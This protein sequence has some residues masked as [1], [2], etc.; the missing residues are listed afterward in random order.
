MDTGTFSRRQWASKSLR[1]TAKE[2]SLVGSHGK[3]PAIAERFSKYQKAAEEATA[4]KKKTSV[5]SLPPLRS[6]NLSVLKKRWE[7][8]QKAVPQLNVAPVSLRSQSASSKLSGLPE[9]SMSSSRLMRQDSLNQK[10]MPCEKPAKIKM[11]METK[12]KRELE[13]QE[14]NVTELDPLSPPLEKSA[15]PLNNLKMMFEKGKSK[16]Q[17]EVGS[18]SEDMD[19][20][21]GTPSLKRS[22]S[23]RD[24][25]AKYQAAVT[26]Q[27]SFTTTR[28]A[29]QSEGSIPSTDHK[30]NTSSTVDGQKVSMLSESNCAKT[31]G[32][33]VHTSPSTA[34]SISENKDPQKAIKFHLPIQESCVSCQK[35]VYPLERLI[36]NQHIYHKTCF[37]CALC[38]TKLSLGSYASLHGIIYCKPHFSQLFKSK[39]NYDE[40]FGHRPHKELW[41]PRMNEQEPE[42]SEKPKP[43]LADLVSVKPAEQLSP[44]VEVSPQAKF[45]DMTEDLETRHQATSSTEKTQNIPVESRR[46]RVAWPPPANSEGSSKVSIPDTEGGKGL[47]KLFR[48]KWPPEDEVPP[49]QQRPERAELKSLQ[50]SSSLRERSRPFSVAQSMKLSKTSEQDAQSSLK[51]ALVRQG[52]L[53]ELR[54]LSKMKKEKAAVQNEAKL[55][56]KKAKD[57]DR[58]SKKDTESPTKL[59]KNEKMP[60]SILKPQQ[61]KKEAQPQQTNKETQSQQTKQEVELLQIKKEAELQQT[62]KETQPQQT[63]NEAERQK[64]K[65]DA[66]L[67]QMKKETQPQQTMKEAELQQKEM[68]AEQQQMKKKALKCHVECEEKPVTC[69]NTSIELQSSRDTPCSPNREDKSHKTSQDMSFWDGEVAEESLTVEE[70]IKRNRYYEDENDDEEEEVAIV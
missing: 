27:A 19:T 6:G 46:L 23:I 17:T 50:R 32:V 33:H 31:N 47:S 36:A 61:T 18:S 41:S 54:S 42:E 34:A 20:Q 64:K 45:T 7:N 28:P 70:M 10:L 62:K 66:E 24:R 43:P 55:P 13:K 53:E 67:Q 60:P 14:E 65:K 38:S 37:R 21:I 57:S 9:P 16:A 39:G 25:M 11:D 69:F 12:Q 59:D 44:K 1:I 51:P 22:T 5:D 2:L 48:P 58:K 15:V 3:S 56:D 52:S 63:S 49:A 4:D 26:R 8:Q 40:G 68:E 29:N 35:T 30:E